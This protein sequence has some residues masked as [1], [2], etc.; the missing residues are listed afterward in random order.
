MLKIWKAKN[1]VELVNLA[2]K[3]PDNFEALMLRYQNRLFHFIK[4]ISYSS[5]EDAEDILQEA[6][7]KIYKNLNSFDDSLQFSTWAY[8]ITRNCVIDSIRKKQV[9]PQKA[10]LETEELAKIFR[11]STDI[12]SETIARDTIKKIKEIISKLPFKYREVIILRFLEEKN[13]EEIMDIVK[14][15]KGTVAS[16]INR[17][18]KILKEE[19]KKQHLI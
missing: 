2:K 7:L 4:R 12:E 1:D 10:R 9:R 14:R 18:K 5:K 17:G 19:A 3:D 15:P 11:S 8:Q 6:F 16:L 13:Y